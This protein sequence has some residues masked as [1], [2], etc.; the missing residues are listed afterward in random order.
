MNWYE[1]RMKRAKKRCK[2]HAKARWDYSKDE[3]GYWY[4]ED[5]MCYWGRRWH[6]LDKK[7]ARAEEKREG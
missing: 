7:S 1:A 3:A 4:H 6:K 5:R 2:Y